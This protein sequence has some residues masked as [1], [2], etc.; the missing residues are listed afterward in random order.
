MD[1]DRL[2]IEI[3]YAMNNYLSVDRAVESVVRRAI[4]LI[5]EK[6]APQ[7]EGSKRVRGLGLWQHFEWEREEPGWRH[8]ELMVVPGVHLS[9]PSSGYMFFAGL[10]YA[11]SKDPFPEEADP[12][13]LLPDFEVWRDNW[14][15]RMRALRPESML[16]TEDPDR[17]SKLLAD[18]V[19][20]TFQSV[21]DS[22]RQSPAK[23]TD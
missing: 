17:Q 2:S 15:R 19:V 20:R 23:N 12:S 6:W 4:P 21:E 14:G 22:F 7:A 8:L 1:E 13:L 16:Q 10:T 18:W 11:L 3:V 9:N 5:E